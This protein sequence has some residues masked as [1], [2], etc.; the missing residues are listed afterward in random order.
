MKESVVPLVSSRQEVDNESL[1]TQ[2]QYRFCFCSSKGNPTL[3]LSLILK[4][5]PTFNVPFTFQIFSLRDYRDFFYEELRSLFERIKETKKGSFF[6]KAVQHCQFSHVC[7]L[8]DLL[9]PF[10]KIV[11][12]IQLDQVKSRLSRAFVRMRARILAASSFVIQTFY[13]FE[14]SCSMDWIT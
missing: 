5:L 9:P 10:R 4:S 11:A 12:Q 8:S 1:M 3:R 6:F 2:V 7:Q 14:Y 13:L